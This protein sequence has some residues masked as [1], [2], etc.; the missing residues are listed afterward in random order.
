MKTVLP[1]NPDAAAALYALDLLEADEREAF[2][3]LSAA[4]DAA[5]AQALQQQRMAAALLEAIPPVPPPAG[6][7]A[8]LLASLP[9]PAAPASLSEMLLQP[10]ILLV[11]SEQK[12]W[13]DTGI[14]GIRRKLLHFDAERNYASNLVSMAAGSVYPSH[15]HAGIEELF[16]LSGQ[17]SLSGHRLGVGDYC[18]ADADTVHDPV[19][20]ETDCVFI[21]FASVNNEM[22]GLAARV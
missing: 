12:P 15:R 21:A 20:A 7:R 6:L 18:R 13:Q 17:A 1:D 3:R 22:I 19:I 9:K 10:G 16:M 2:E 4:N 11:R 8:R 5:H 14:P